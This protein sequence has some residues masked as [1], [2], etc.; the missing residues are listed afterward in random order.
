MLQVLGMIAIIV[1]ALIAVILILAARKPD[2]FHLQRATIIKAP[3]EKI[4]PLLDDFR[5]WQAW[6]PWEKLDPALNRTYSGPQSGK[7]SAY[8]WQGN[9]KVGQGRMEITESSPP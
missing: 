4:F 9:S 8:A 7:G 6:S 3:P 1:V 2:V 5:N